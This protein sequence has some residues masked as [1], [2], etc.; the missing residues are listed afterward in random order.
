MTSTVKASLLGRVERM[1]SRI[2]LA[3]LAGIGMAELGEFRV[4]EQQTV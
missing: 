3:P 2:G 4:K 1:R